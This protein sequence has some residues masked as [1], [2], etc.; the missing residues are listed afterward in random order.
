MCGTIF[1]QKNYVIYGSVP[2]KYNNTTVYMS[3]LSIDAQLNA[4]VV[5]TDSAIVENGRFVLKGTT[6]DSISLHIISLGKSSGSFIVPNSTKLKA[7][8]VDIEP[9]GYFR[10]SGTTLNE[11]LT[12]F[13]ELPMELSQQMASIMQERQE[14]IEKNEWTAEKDSEVNATVKDLSTRFIKLASLIVKENIENP[15]GQYILVM[16]GGNIEKDVLDEIEPKLNTS[17]RQKLEERK[18]LMAQMMNQ[19]QSEDSVSE[20]IKQGNK[21]VD[22]E[23]ET[24]DGTKMKLSQILKSKKLV[25]LDFWAS[26]CAPCLREMPEIADLYHKYQEK[27]FEIVGISLDKERVPWK[28]TVENKKM[29]WIQLID[30]DMSN[31]IANIYEVVAIPHTILI[32]ENGTIVATKLRGKELKDKVETLLSK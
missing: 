3:R 8:F 19:S 28:N 16:L 10:I 7:E 29:T 1:A 21:F 14:A 18:R 22:F 27:G 9:I 30:S 6:E 24:L 32:D 11:Q 23:G 5:Y 13:M 26:W 2:E 4:P 17:I 20:Q 25:L 15:V 31:S 12:K